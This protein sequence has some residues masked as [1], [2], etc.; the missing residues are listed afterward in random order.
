MRPRASPPTETVEL[1]GGHVPVSDKIGEGEYSDGSL[2]S[3][4]SR[5]RERETGW[6]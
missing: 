6:K 3:G 4:P 5:H 1:D 2:S